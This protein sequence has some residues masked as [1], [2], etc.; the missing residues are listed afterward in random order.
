VQVSPYDR[1]FIYDP[2]HLANVA[3]RANDPDDGIDYDEIIQATEADFRAGRGRIFASD[4]EISAWLDELLQQA[5]RRRAR[6]RAA[7]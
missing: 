7:S 4:D 3:D 6:V 5:L 1:N 2:N